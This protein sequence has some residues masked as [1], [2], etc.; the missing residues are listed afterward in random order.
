MRDL[1]KS[2]WLVGLLCVF[3]LGARMC[4]TYWHLCVDGQEP[5]IELR[6][7]NPAFGDGNDTPGREDVDLNLADDGIIKLLV[8]GL[9]APLLCSLL[10]IFWLLSLFTQLLPFRRDRI[11]VHAGDL[12]SLH[13][14]PR[15]PPL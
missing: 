4:G 12:Y 10:I 13:A 1:H 7:G 3:L 11:P 15:A 14:P 2:G 6:S 5:P 9:D 8:I